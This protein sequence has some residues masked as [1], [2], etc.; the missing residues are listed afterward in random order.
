MII[1][2]SVSRFTFS[3]HFSSTGPGNFNMYYLISS[4]E[5]PELR[6]LVLGLREVKGRCKAD[7]GL[8]VDPLCESRIPSCVH[9]VVLLLWIL[10]LCGNSGMAWNAVPWKRC[11]MAARARHVSRLNTTADGSDSEL[12]HP[13]EKGVFLF[14]RTPKM[15]TWSRLA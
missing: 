1:S 12:K 10:E 14:C 9:H 2:Q 7:R 5:Q 15:K 11:C 13:S 6:D 8:H 3:W 4:S